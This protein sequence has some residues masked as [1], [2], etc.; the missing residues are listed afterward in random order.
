MYP[1]LFVSWIHSYG[2]LMAVGFYAGWW[3]AAVR[4][5]QEGIDP[6][7]VGNIVLI[8]ILSGVVGARLLWFILYRDPSESWWTIVE[9][10]KGGL[11]FYGGLISAV[12]AD[13]VY[14]RRRGLHAL[15]V[16]D[17]LAPAVAVGQGFGRIGCF[18]NGCCFGGVCSPT[19][20]LGVR[21]PALFG[22]DGGVVGSP[23]YRAHLDL[24]WVTREATVS[25]PV[26]PT[27]LYTAAF[28]FL[29]ALVLITAT[30]HKRRHGE[31]FGLLGILH[32][33]SRFAVELVRRDSPGIILGLKAGQ[34]GAIV[35]FA[36]GALLLVWTRRRGTPVPW[37]TRAS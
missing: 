14:L 27:Q 23:V 18:L 33:V 32:G 3:L 2:L 15:R 36:A 24:A 7:I 20:P 22:Q 26:H 1:T 29:T 11:V 30:P 9:V 16:A 34:L 4:A 13:I 10:W 12:V 35:I 31:I 6:D 28:L 8:S 5:K 19:F 25:L 37:A 17:I 21:F